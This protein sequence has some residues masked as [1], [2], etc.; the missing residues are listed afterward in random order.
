M[1]LEDGTETAPTVA[2]VSAVAQKSGIA[3]LVIATAQ[4]MLVLDTTIVNVALPSIQRSL[5][6][7]TTSLNWVITAYA[8]AFGGLLLVGGRAGDLLGRR[9]V[10][11]FGLVI[12]TLASLAGG[13]A[14]NGSALIIARIVQ[15]FGAAIAVPTA[16]S[17]L[18]TTFPEGSARNKAMGV[19]SAMGGLG[20]VA[21][22]LL[23][24]VLTQYADW[25]WVLFINVPLG[26]L[27]LLG[28]SA[29]LE[30]GR[31]RG[32]L[33]IVGAVAAT[34]GI[35]AVVYAIN[36][37]NSN[38]WSDGATIGCFVAGAVLLIAFLFVERASRAPVMPPR[39]IRERNRAGANLV[40][41]LTG[42]GMLSMFYFLTLYI[43][44]VRGYS[45][46]QAG[47]AYL[48]YVVGILLSAGALGPKLVSLFPMR[49][50]MAVGMLFGAGGLVFYMALTTTTNYYA[51]MLP[52]LLVS[53]FGA[54]LTFV[55]CT[56]TAVWGTDAQ[57]TGIAA[58]LINIS[59]QI[60]GAIGL[61]ALAAVASTVTRSHLSSGT[62]PS[63]ALTDGYVVSLVVGAA[64]FAVG[65]VIAM[66]MVNVRL[67]GP[68][69]Q[70]PADAKAVK[71]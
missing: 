59:Q 12:F 50:I 57:E 65:V 34:L 36:R 40:M 41:L 38:G 15:G 31:E 7:E 52:A 25:R 61:A 39:V 20:S 19:Y 37:G 11:R 4:L 58:G 44:V 9:R 21:G 63:A 46:V 53:G 56:M 27:V 30:G 1:S 62:H 28:S 33:D 6:M 24:G 67:E 13:L 42:A 35:G 2:G 69:G 66:T 64:I 23:G 32:P 48:P 14:P 54:G 5:H 26:A 71:D 43:Q 47:L 8:V 45:P 3:L 55:S 70:R 51:L 49:L 16:L 60:G 22:L 68:A 17:L 10:F 18:A 29:L